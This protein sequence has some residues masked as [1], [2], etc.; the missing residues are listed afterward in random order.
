M[1]LE[2]HINNIISENEP[3]LRQEYFWQN[4]GMLVENGAMAEAIMDVLENSGEIGPTRYNPET[5]SI[6]IGIYRNHYDGT[7]TAYRKYVKEFQS[8]YTLQ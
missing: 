1:G 2:K 8:K 4:S 5:R 3:E 6:E 7:E